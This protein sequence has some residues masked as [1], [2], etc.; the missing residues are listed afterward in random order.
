MVE[1]PSVDLAGQLPG[2]PAAQAGR[3]ASAVTGHVF[4]ELDEYAS[5]NAFWDGDSLMLDQPAMAWSIIGLQIDEEPAAS[6]SISGIL[7]GLHVAVSD[8]GNGR[9]RFI[10]SNLAED[11]VITIP[12]GD[13]TNAA[14]SIYFA[15]I[16]PLGSSAQVVTTLSYGLPDADTTPPAWTDGEGIISVDA[17]G[18]WVK[19]DWHEATDD[20]SPPVEYLVFQALS[21]EDI[22]WELP[23]YVVPAAFLATH[24]SVPE[25]NS[26][27]FDYAVRARDAAGNV[28]G[29]TNFISASLLGGFSTEIFDWEP[30]DRLELGWQDPLLD[31]RLQLQGPGFSQGSP[32][33][34]DGMSG[35]VQ[36]SEDSAT[37]GQAIETATLLPGAPEG[38]YKL[39]IFSEA[40]QTYT[41]RLYD[42]DGVLKQ[43]LG[44]ITP[45]FTGEADY[46]YL[47]YGQGSWPQFGAVEAGQRLQVSWEGPE[48]DVNLWVQAP[49]F[50][51]GA[52][53]F[54]DDLQDRLDF[55]EDN[56]VSNSPL[57]WIRFT[58]NAE[59]GVYSFAIA[60]D[61][62]A[63]PNPETLD[64]TWAVY[65]ELDNVV[66][67]PGMV[68]LKD[69]GEVFIIDYVDP[70]FWLDFQPAVE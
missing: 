42:S 21:S 11:T 31:G 25:E 56:M 67:G 46:A 30:G 68:R 33:E 22:N 14:G 27:S 24:V 69:S 8:Y 65:D 51:Q 10:G 70:F 39:V 35:M 45:G 47:R 66:L 43:D 17:A 48:Q 36:F 60:W 15:M 44:N 18:S 20:Q 19:L 59:P 61:K 54:P 3:H 34:P 64:L 12:V 4:S 37:N 41:I 16:A 7:E 26:A 5:G 23:Q 55:S 38:G 28:T 1:T 53:Q 49:G 32:D 52:P 50:E 57:E 6:L 58:A 63:A 40:G 29:N 62:S 13:F 9:W 2:L